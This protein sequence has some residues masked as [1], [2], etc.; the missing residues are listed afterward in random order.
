MRSEL[1]HRLHHFKYNLR[2]SILKVV[3]QF[4]YEENPNSADEDPRVTLFKEYDIK[5]DFINQE[6]RKFKSL[7]SNVDSFIN[8]NSSH[9][10]SVLLM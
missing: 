6:Y 5:N 8:S 3:K 1:Y 9:S 10:T 7:L 2:F 4:E